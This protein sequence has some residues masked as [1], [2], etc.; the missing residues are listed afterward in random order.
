MY[1]IC[2]NEV[3]L[4]N[5]VPGSLNTYEAVYCKGLFLCPAHRNCRE[6][7]RYCELCEELITYTV[8]AEDEH[9]LAKHPET[10]WEPYLSN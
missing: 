1:C 7:Y 6:V 8:F 4:S 10:L 9:E 5:P 3:F 2:G